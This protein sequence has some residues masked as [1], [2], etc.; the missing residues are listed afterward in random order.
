MFYRRTETYSLTN[1]I[2][3][4]GPG[5]THGAIP[6]YD[7]VKWR[8]L[9][10]HLSRKSK[11]GVIPSRWYSFA[12]QMA[13]CEAQTGADCHLVKIVLREMDIRLTVESLVAGGFE[14]DD[15]NWL[16]VIMPREEKKLDARCVPREDGEIHTLLIDSSA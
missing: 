16:D 8:A 13:E 1:A 12:P 5:Q 4:G 15:L 9:P 3:E 7:E 11:S 2:P 6:I 10:E 14:L